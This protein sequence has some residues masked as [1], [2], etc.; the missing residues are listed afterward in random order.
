MKIC[1]YYFSMEKSFSLENMFHNGIIKKFKIA[2][3]I[4]INTLK[5]ENLTF[6]K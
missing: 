6:S 3:K 2:M 1:V 4:N 5:S